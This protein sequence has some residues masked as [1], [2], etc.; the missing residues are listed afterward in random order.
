MLKRFSNCMVF[1]FLLSAIFPYLSNAGMVKKEQL[2]CSCIGMRESPPNKY[3]IYMGNNTGFFLSF[4]TGNQI[5]VLALARQALMP[6]SYIPSLF[7]CFIN[8]IHIE[9]IRICGSVICKI[10]L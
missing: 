2:L 1:M 8:V 4:Y 10:L 7:F 3:I 5:Q 6:Q 9:T